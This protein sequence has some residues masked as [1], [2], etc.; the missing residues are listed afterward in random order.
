M[1]LG[2]NSVNSG[3]L[4]NL[5]SSNINAGKTLASLSSGLRINKASDDAAGLAI[6]NQL[7]AQEVSTQQ[8]IR[9]TSDGASLVNIS[10]GALS[11]IS[12]LLSR[13]R[14]LAMQ[15]SNG[16]L[17]DT[18]RKTLQGEYNQIKS[19]IDRISNVTN[20]NGKMLLDG[21]LSPNAPQKNEIQAGTGNN[22]QDKINLNVIP[23]TNTTTLGIAGTDI[24]SAS[25]AQAA[26]TS[27]DSAMQNISNTRG[28]LG[29]IQNR[30][31][32]TIANLEVTNENY[33][34]ARS[35]IQDQDFGAA[36]SNFS[37][38]NLLLQTGYSVLA[39]SNRI[40]QQQIGS[41]LNF[42]I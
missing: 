30:L 40:N 12:D 5:I 6:A 21:S 4:Q 11:S 3:V 1:A 29:A 36:I 16:T 9:N 34:A 24:M 41:L 42:K 26:L 23:Q 15:S 2:I 35:Q 10:E 38:D 18:Q 39:Q 22:S 14:E 13:G 17:N 32:S 20:F 37:R 19:E 8:A 33:V 31:T 28:E 7:S 27:I 25:N